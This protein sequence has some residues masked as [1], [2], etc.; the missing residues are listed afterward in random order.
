MNFLLEASRDTHHAAFNIIPLEKCTV[1]MILFFII[2]II[3]MTVML[4]IFLL[5]DLDGLL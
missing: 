5:R 2:I 1:F 4:Y 3:L